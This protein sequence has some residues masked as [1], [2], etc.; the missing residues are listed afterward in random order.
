MSSRG[1]KS[2]GN[3]S[4]NKSMSRSTNKRK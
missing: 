3:D 4:T 1:K 2:G